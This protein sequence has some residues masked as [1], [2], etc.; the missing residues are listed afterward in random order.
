MRSVCWLVGR[1]IYIISHKNWDVGALDSHQSWEMDLIRFLKAV[2]WNFDRFPVL[3]V[4]LNPAKIY[5]PHQKY[6]IDLAS[7]D[8]KL[9]RT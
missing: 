5:E 3:W 4:N 6:K 1:K 9:L 7:S 8:L 2:Y